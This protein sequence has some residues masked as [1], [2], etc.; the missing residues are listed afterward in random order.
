MTEVM[1]DPEHGSVILNESLVD[2]GAAMSALTKQHP[3][4]AALVQWA[5]NMRP[6]GGQR[7]A[8]GVFE[9]DKFVLPAKIFD[10]F[11]VAALA[12]DVD[13]IVSGVL[14]TTESLALSR[15]DFEA[16]DPDEEDVWN[17]IA[18][19]LDLDS[20][21]REMWRELFTYS[22]FSCGIWWGRKTFKVRGKTNKGV[23]RKKTFSNLAVPLGLTLLDPLKV[24]PVGS[25]LFNQE[26]LVYIADRNETS[27]ILNALNTPGV[28]PLVNSFLLRPY[29]PDPRER[30][31]FSE[32]GVT[33]SQSL[34]LCNP[35][36]V[37]RHTETRPAY[38]KFA[39]LRMKSVFELLDMKQQLKQMD[40]AQLLGGPLRVDQRIATPE[41]WK[42]IGSARV[43]DKVFSVDGKPTEIVGVFPQ[44][45]LSMYRVSFKDGAEVFCD[46]THPWTVLNRYGT[47]R[48]IPLKDIMAEGL[49]DSNGT[50]NGVYRHRVPIADPLELP[51]VDLPLDPYLIGTF[52]GDGSCTQSMPK[53]HSAEG[54]DFPWKEVLPPGVTVSQYEKREG[55]CPQYGLKGSRWRHNEVTEGLRNLGLWGMETEDKFIPEECLWASAEQ[56]WSLLQ[57]ICDT[58]GHSPCAGGVEVSTVSEKLALGLVQLVQSLG[59]VAKV[60]SRSVR[61]NERPCYRVWIS[62]NQNEAPFRLK[63]KA[64]SWR[65]RK[66]PYARAIV[67]IERV[68]DAEAVCIKTARDDG[69]FLTEGMVVTHNTNFIILITKGTDQHPA[70]PG[71]VE[72]L[73]TQ[74]RTVARVP[75]IVGDHRLEVKIITPSTD[76]TLRPERY[77]AIDSRITARL[78]QMFMLG[79]YAAGGKGDDSVKLARVVAR[80]ME[81]RRHMIRRSLETHVFRPT[82][83]MNAEFTSEPDLRFHPKRVALDFDQALAAFLLDLRDR[84]DIS[85]DSILSEF[86]FSQEE[87]ARKRE[88]EAEQYDEIFQTAVPYSGNITTDINA[89]AAAKSAPGGAAGGGGASSPNIPDHGHAPTGEPVPLGPSSRSKT[90]SNKK[91]GTADTKSAGRRQ[92]GTKNGG[93]SAPGSGQGQ[94]PRNPRKKSK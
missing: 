51:H 89:G 13:D 88:R 81:S 28:D 36:S 53:I 4:V 65:P 78:Y 79:N 45:E 38:Q 26:Q 16:E 77:N 37:W 50:S 8:S 43:G 5:G 61:C 86:D 30:G 23:T 6:T 40:R 15:M 90:A 67:K 21:L 57:G 19:D 48:T 52:L 42:P 55:F 70:R 7:Y 33:S 24:I 68:A 46:E 29:N 41:G 35:Q 82:V 49:V 12:V 71:E 59:S 9:R 91:T 34:F 85:R 3:E 69:L 73:Q 2:S 31:Y 93:G 17:Q 14:E 80:G 11:K 76:N 63:R 66:H 22:Q 60:S 87:E 74:V 20:R 62:L 27:S 64:A 75:I 1:H 56:R 94:T 92:G 83:Q 32:L 84:G 25:F 44:G 10:Q 72:S 54:E 39:S 18:Q 47:K 58:D